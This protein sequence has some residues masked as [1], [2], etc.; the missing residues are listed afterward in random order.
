MPQTALRRF[1]DRLLLRSALTKEEQEAIMSLGG[2][3]DRCAPNDDIVSS[4]ERVERACLVSSGLAGRYDQM[5]DGER[6]VTSIYVAGDMCDLHSVVAP[7]VSW[8]I[9]ALSRVTVIRVHHRQL[10]DLCIRYPGVAIAFWRDGT[11]DAAIFAKWIGNLGRKNGKA[12]IGHLFCE[13]GMRGEAAGLGSKTAY[14]L[15]LTQAQLADTVGLTAVHV[16]RTLKD[17]NI[18]SLVHFRRGRVEIPDWEA[19]T[20][21]AEFDPAY[22]MLEGPPR[23]VFPRHYSIAAPAVH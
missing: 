9:T 5:L 22:L 19:L 4:H 23:R 20:L 12:R 10:R 3:I 16:N 1:L 21:L 2:D 18:G 17:L 13:M 8:S 14:E 7:R 6:Q 11:A 15:P